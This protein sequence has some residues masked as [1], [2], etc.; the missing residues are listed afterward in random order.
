VIWH[1]GGQGKNWRLAHRTQAWAAQN[2][3]PGLRSALKAA[4]QRTQANARTGQMMDAQT[5]DN[6]RKVKEAL[7]QAGKTDSHMYTRAVAIVRTGSDP[8]I[9]DLFRLGG[10]SLNH[11]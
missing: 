8:G 7:E 2:H 10:S 6:W 1:H 9:P 3:P 11:D 5:R 4:A